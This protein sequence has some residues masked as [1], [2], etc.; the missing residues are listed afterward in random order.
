MDKMKDVFQESDK[1]GDGVI[2]IEEFVEF[3]KKYID[4]YPQLKIINE[5]VIANFEKYDTDKDNSLNKKEFEAILKDVDSS[6]T[7]LPA[8]AQWF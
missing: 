5:N 6:L 7:L 1:N 3:S 4:K 2:Q 8:T